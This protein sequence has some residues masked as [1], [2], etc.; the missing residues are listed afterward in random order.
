MKRTTLNDLRAAVEKQDRE[1]VRML[2]DRAKLSV[3]IGRIKADE[4]REVYDP[5]QEAEVYARL[6]GMNDG[7]LTTP[8]LRDVYREI[9]SVSRSLQAPT[10]V[11]YLGPEAS[12]SHLA[13]LSHFGRRAVLSPA[14]TIAEVFD[15]VEKRGSDWGVVPVE[16]S[17]EGAVKPTQ[18]RLISTPL[19]VRA[20]VFLRVSLCLLSRRSGRRGIRRIYSHPQALAQ[21]RGWLDRNVPRAARLEVPSTTAAVLKALEE[22]DG[23]AIGSSLAAVHYGLGIL[24]SGIEDSPLNTTRFFVIGRGEGRPTDRDKTSILFGTPHVPGSLLNA[25]EP[26][27]REGINMTRIESYPLRD[28]MWE[29]LFFADFLGHRRDEK[30]GRCLAEME[31]RTTLIKVLGSYPQGREG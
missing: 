25:L 5:A 20:E 16:N 11:A 31:S 29:Y 13:A 8:C 21:C 10:T 28:R 1:L 2:N 3:E 19:V 30:V 24:E 26:L 17:T 9:L 7:P 14:A 18:D 23:A 27:A 6:E 12:F 4:G 15:A 22:T